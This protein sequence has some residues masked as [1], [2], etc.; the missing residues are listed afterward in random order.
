MIVHLLE[1]IVDKINSDTI[2]VSELLSMPISQRPRNLKRQCKRDDSKAQI[3]KLIDVDTV[4]SQ[5]SKKR[6]RV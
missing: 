5:R 2:D 3:V 4:V 6:I 1:A